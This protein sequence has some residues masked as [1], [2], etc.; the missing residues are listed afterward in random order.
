MAEGTTALDLALTTEGDADGSD[1]IVYLVG[2]ENPSSSGALQYEA[3]HDEVASRQLAPPFW[4]KP[5]IQAVLSSFVQRIQELEDTVWQILE[6][7]TLAG[8]DLPRLKVLGRIVGQPR[9]GFD[10]ETYR[11]VIAGRGAANVSKGRGRDILVALNALLG[12]EDY[13]LTET[14]D[15][16]I[17]VTALDG[18]DDQSLAMVTEILPDVRSAGVGLQFLFEDSA[19]IARWGFASWGSD[20]WASV[21][22]L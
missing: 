22:L 14:G 2:S 6:L 3:H 12:S 11:K 19:G 15:A 20:D 1:Q 4:G 16:T 17:Y 7:H 10:E 9:L 18:I 8:A 5:N 21:R 13:V